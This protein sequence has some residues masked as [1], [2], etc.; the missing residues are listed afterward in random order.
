MR[1]P[2]GRTDGTRRA[3]VH[4][5]TTLSLVRSLTAIADVMG[6]PTAEDAPISAVEPDQTRKVAQLTDPDD[7]DASCEPNRGPEGAQ[8]EAAK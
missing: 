7:L 1:P 3:G 2:D 6:A 5:L 4:G 8:P